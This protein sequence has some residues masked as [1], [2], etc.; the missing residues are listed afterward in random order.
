MKDSV[1]NID[2]C[3]RYGGEEFLI[4]L[5]DTDRNGAMIL[6]ERVRE[7][8]QNTLVDGLQVTISIG[9]STYPLVDVATYDAFIETADKMLY[10][11]K[12]SGRNCVR[13]THTDE[14]AAAVMAAKV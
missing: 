12:V 2:I 6:A 11:C 4:I 1:R 10:V 13:H 14:Q 7:N 3:C 5:P 8:V 9:V